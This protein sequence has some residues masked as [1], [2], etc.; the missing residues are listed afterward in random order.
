MTFGKPRYNRNYE[1]ELLRLC[2]KTGYKIVG[3]ASKLF[4]YAITHFKLN[5]IISYC[6]YSKFNGRVYEIIGMQF[7]KLTQPQEIW[8][9]DHQNITANLLRSK[10]YDKLFGTNYGKGTNNELL[11][12]EHG[13][14]PVYDCGQK[15]FV[16]M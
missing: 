13:W 16:Y 8:S 3:G 10:G 5:N 14:L 4:K 9:K 12:L 15:V 6:N 11:M 7:T 1:W 2:T